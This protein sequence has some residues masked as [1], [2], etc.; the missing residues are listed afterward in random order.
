MCPCVYTAVCTGASDQPRTQSWTCAASCAEPVSTSVSPR[1]PA[2]AVTLAKL[3]T[4]ATPGATSS[5][6]S[7]GVKGGCSRAEMA[8][9]QYFSATS[10]MRPIEG[11]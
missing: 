9:V 6:A 1:S 3:D 2:T 7:S 5:S 8:P 4:K 10:A 11:L